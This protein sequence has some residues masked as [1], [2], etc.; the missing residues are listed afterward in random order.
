VSASRTPRET[1]ELLLHTY[2]HGRRPDIA[3]LYAPEVHIENLWVR[4]GVPSEFRGDREALR[5]R[6]ELSEQLL[7]FDAVR[8]LH[9]HEGADPENIVLELRFDVTLR[10]TGEKLG[11]GF[12]WIMRI[13]DGLIVSSRDY[14]NPLETVE[15]AKLLESRS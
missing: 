7:S 10:A 5:A 1:V 2:V 12:V 8:D 11:I 3:D 4:D 9:I 13:V 6:Y 14:S 15:L